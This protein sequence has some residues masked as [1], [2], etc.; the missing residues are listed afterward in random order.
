MLP[1]V[2]GVFAFG[3]GLDNVRFGVGELLGLPVGLLGLLIAGPD[4]VEKVKGLVPVVLESGILF[5]EVVEIYLLS[6]G[7]ELV[8]HGLG[9][10]ARI[11]LYV[12]VNIKVLHAG[13]R[14][15]GVIE[16]TARLLQG[17]LSLGDAVLLLRGVF[18]GLDL[19][20]YVPI[21]V[22]GLLEELVVLGYG[23][24]RLDDGLVGLFPRVP[25]EE[26]A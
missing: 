18:A 2:R 8:V 26:A 7:G 19:L 24:V 15:P 4:L 21:G 1:I 10:Q 20:L 12:L 5:E 11:L 16:V 3:R 13:E 14:L 23:L 6:F 22:A 25:V 17:V 9:E